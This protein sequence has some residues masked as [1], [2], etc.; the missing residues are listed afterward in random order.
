MNKTITVALAACLLASCGTSP[1][2]Q[3]EAK[4]ITETPTFEHI[5]CFSA[6]T[7]ILDDYAKDGVNR[8]N[9]GF[10]YYDSV[11][12]KTPVSI[13]ADCITVTVPVSCP[14]TGLP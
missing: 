2:T 14:R 10:A 1:S 4:D 11:T 13:R 6:G 5:T 7:R 3:A 9:S 12:A 8:M